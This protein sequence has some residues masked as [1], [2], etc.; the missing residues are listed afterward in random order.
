MVIGEQDNI[1]S[2]KG[3]WFKGLWGCWSSDVGAEEEEE[4]LGGN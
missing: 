3:V 4:S 1:R 2:K